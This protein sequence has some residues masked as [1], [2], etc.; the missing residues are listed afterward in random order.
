MN[1]IALLLQHSSVSLGMVLFLFGA[2]I[3]SFINL[4][5][6]R[7]PA[8]LLHQSKAQCLEMFA[9]TTAR[10][11]DDPPPPNLVRP[12]S[13]CPNCLSPLRAIHNIPLF[14]FLFLGGKCGFCRQSISIRYPIVEGFAALLS[15]YLGSVL[16]MGWTLLFALGFT[17]ALITLSL[18]DWEHQILPDIIVLPLLWIGLIANSFELFIDIQSAVFGTV[19]G[20]MV[21]WSIYQIHHKI[22]GKEGMGYGDFKLLAAIGAWFGW[23]MLP[24]VL[25]LASVSGTVIALFMMMLGKHSRDMPVPFGPYLAVA[26]WIA[27]VWGDSILENY[28]QI[29]NL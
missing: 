9:P 5:V 24:V 18:I 21:L 22:T 16:G 26:A 13:R 17:Y 25:L 8:L 23:Q 11:C 15:V 29:F 28:L 20:Y 3:G 14:G 12:A 7:L 2:C 10:E 1:D 6:L 19:S 4:V 27:L